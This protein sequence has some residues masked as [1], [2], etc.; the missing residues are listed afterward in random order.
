[1]NKKILIIEDND[2]LRQLEKI[3]LEEN[4][5]EVFE[6][7]N[8]KDG[9]RLAIQ[10]L[11]DLI[12]MDIRLPYKKKG[13]GAA[14]A[15]RNNTVTQNIP[16]IFVTGCTESELK[17]EIKTLPICTYLRKPFLPKTLHETIKQFLG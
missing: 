4:G 11:P 2:E 10:K 1:V 7:N 13:I 3:S 6:T 5:Y 8:T 17:N 16:I 14:K 12:L 9:I 15:L